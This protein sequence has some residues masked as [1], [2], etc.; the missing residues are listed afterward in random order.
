VASR[1]KNVDLVFATS[2]PLTVGLVAL[3]LKAIKKWRYVFEVRD[4][5]PEFPIQMGA[6]QNKLVVNLLRQFERR[7]YRK[8][9]YVITLSPG[10]MDG[11]LACGTPTDKVSV[12]PNMSK[13]D[14]FYPRERS[15]EVMKQHHID[16]NK[17]N[18]VHF[19]AMGVANGLEYV[20]RTAAILQQ[21]GDSSIQ[22]LIVGDGSTLPALQKQA[23]ELKLQ[24][25]SFFGQFNMA[26]L[27]ELVNCCDVSLV[28][29]KNLPILYTNSPNKLFDSLSA[30]KPIIVNSAGWTKELVE[31]HHCGF[32]VDPESPADFA[33]KL[34]YYKGQKELLA[35][36]EGNARKLSIEMFDKS[37]LSSQVANVLENVCRG[38]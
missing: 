33:E 10:M 24:N 28:S 37:I 36:W 18:V 29:F 25:V 30:G 9:E 32:Y 31:E 4:L 12:I 6:I 22:F 11:V 3:Y 38:A 27:S 13:P 7:I 2:T 16:G 34:Q 17:F 23:D 14:K 21:Q 15:V 26:A 8:A 19:G 1:Q 20:I 5:W 35:E